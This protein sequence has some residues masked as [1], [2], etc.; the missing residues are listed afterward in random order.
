MNPKDRDTIL[1]RVDER[2]RNIWRVTE[3]MKRHQELQNSNIAEALKM[4]YTSKAWV[5]IGQWVVG[6]IVLLLIAGV[7]TKLQGL[8]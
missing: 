3:D 2:T 1:I 4:C 8:W 5:R 7:E 6:G